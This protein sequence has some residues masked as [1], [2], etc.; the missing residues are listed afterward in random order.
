MDARDVTRRF[1]SDLW[2]TLKSHGFTRRT[3]R[4]AWRDVGDSVDVI[5]VNLIGPLADAIGCTSYSFAAFVASLP[6]YL[7]SD[8]VRSD[9][10]G[11]R[12]PQY[13][14]SELKM[15]LSKTLPQP[16]FRPF[17]S[18]VRGNPPESFVKHRKGLMA[19]LRADVHDRKDTWFVRE[20]AAN[21]SECVADLLLVI[22]RDGLPLLQRLHDPC[23]VAEIVREGQLA[24]RPD[25]PVGRDLLRAALQACDER[26]G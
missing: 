26:Q 4:V 13:W 14:E 22:E 1:R 16:W 8:H 10:N 11:R 19:V 7:R 15:Q 5:E 25:S 18:P 12:R 21:L 2:P 24:I 20:D 23:A 17:A 3:E 9:P 6:A